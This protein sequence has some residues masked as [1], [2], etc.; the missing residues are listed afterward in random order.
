MALTTKIKFILLFFLLFSCIGKSNDDCT[1]LTIKEYYYKNAYKRGTV[2]LISAK[3]CSRAEDLN[4]LI[5]ENSEYILNSETTSPEDRKKYLD[6]NLVS[7]IFTLD[8]LDYQKAISE[9]TIDWSE[10]IK[11][12]VFQLGS[13]MTYTVIST[14][15]GDKGP[16]YREYINLDIKNNKIFDING[17]IDAV[18]KN[19]LN[20]SI[21]TYAENRKRE[22]VD[23]YQDSFS[24]SADGMLI[25]YLDVFA[26]SYYDLKKVTL[27]IGLN[28]FSHFTPEGIVFKVNVKDKNFLSD[29]ERNRVEEYTSSITIPYAE[30][31]NYYDKNSNLYASLVE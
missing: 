4:K 25:T 6:N 31:K 8:S 21:T 19:S 12:Q 18:K 22:I 13:I 24:E 16:P 28:D 20:A 27:E 29:K 11:T 3:N 17:V 1:N 26:Q 9:E 5:L 2:K 14:Y 10:E 15:T 7:E 23:N 30:F